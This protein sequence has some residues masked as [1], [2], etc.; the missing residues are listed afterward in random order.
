MISSKALFDLDSS[1][2]L[3][4]G[5]LP[6]SILGISNTHNPKSESFCFIKSKQYLEEFNTSVLAS[7][8]VGILFEKK[9]LEQYQEYVTSHEVYKGANWCAEVSDVG[10]SMCLFSKPFY[11]KLFSDL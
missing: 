9:F 4:K 7:S 5:K 1:F 2:K 3:L 6:D 11:D 10:H 8:K